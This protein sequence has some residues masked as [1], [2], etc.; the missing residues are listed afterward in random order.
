MSRGDTTPYCRKCKIRGWVMAG[1]CLVAL[2]SGLADAV[3]PGQAQR[4]GC[5]L[6]QAGRPRRL[7]A[8]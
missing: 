2:A 8:R 1:G 3:V 7:D 4:A 6:T 5:R